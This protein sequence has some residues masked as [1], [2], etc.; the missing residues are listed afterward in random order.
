MQN[1]S[2]PPQ[3]RGNLCTC[4]ELNSGGTIAVENRTMSNGGS[5][6]IW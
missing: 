1:G 3:D 4:P 5:F 6:H 2:K